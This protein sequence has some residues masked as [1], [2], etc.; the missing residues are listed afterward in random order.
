MQKT[1]ADHVEIR[2]WA[3]ERGGTPAIIDHPIARADR[4]GIRID[5]PGE[6]HDALMSEK[7]PASWDEF[8]Q[9]FE[10]QRLL[11]FYDTEVSD[12]DPS[13]WYHFE[14]REQP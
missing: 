7:R 1:T 4:R 5:F 9:I 8:F 10:E 13:E 2:R 14:K 12:G 11:F 6:D 3:E